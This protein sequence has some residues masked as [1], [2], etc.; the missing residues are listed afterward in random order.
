MKTIAY[1]ISI[2]VILTIMAVLL[3]PNVTDVKSYVPAACREY[4][5]TILQRPDRIDFPDSV[6]VT[7]I[8]SST[9]RM[10]S[11]VDTLDGNGYHC[12]VKYMCE[13]RFKSGKFILN[14]FKIL[15]IVY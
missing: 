6:I 4:I 7:M 3:M 12:R 2:M 8:N 1:M 9:Y 15:D 13:M 10:L 14:A 5:K 11:Y